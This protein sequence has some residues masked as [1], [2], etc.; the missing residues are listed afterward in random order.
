MEILVIIAALLGLASLG[1]SSVAL[2][3][4]IRR[5]LIIGDSITGTHYY[6]Y[7][8]IP[9][10]KVKGVF[11][12]GQQVVYI[13]EHALAEIKSFNPTD[14]VFIGGVNNIASQVVGHP[15]SDPIILAANVAKDLTT[16][17]KML[18][19]KDRRLW[20]GSTTP[21]FGYTKY[22]GPGKSI[23]ELMKR[24]TLITNEWIMKQEGKLYYKFIDTSPMG[25]SSNVMYK[26]YTKDGL[27]PYTIA[28][29][30][31]LAKIVQDTLIRG[32]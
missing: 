19:N 30:K 18:Y 31:A 16:A 9:G 23:S 29:R 14:I 13:A 5:I 28:G 7:I 6:D 11:W 12:G 21:W 32:L 20:I 2:S 24:V 15:K 17:W 25:N 3:K 10:A 8:N 26:E 4:Y 1:N 22:F 27:H